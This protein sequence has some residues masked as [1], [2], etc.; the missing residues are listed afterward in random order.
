MKR[1]GGD[2]GKLEGNEGELRAMEE[3]TEQRNGP[4][5]REI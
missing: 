5:R 1:N 3:N 4:E 2:W